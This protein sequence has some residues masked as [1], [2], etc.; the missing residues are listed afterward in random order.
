MSLATSPPPQCP[1]HAGEA[2]PAAPLFTP[3]MPKG[4][5]G[6][7][8]L[9][10]MLK[11]GLHSGIGMFLGTSYETQGVGR[12]PIPTLPRL[13]SR[14]LYMVRTP[15]LIRRVLVSEAD[16]FPKSAL[17][18]DML[19]A[20]TGYSIFIS[21]GEAWRRHRRLMDPAFETARIKDVF[22]MMVQAAD[23]CLARI[24]ARAGAPGAARPIRIDLEMTHYAADIIFRT[25]FSEPLPNADAKRFFAAFE[26]FQ[27][28]AYAH[29]MLRLAKVPTQWL[30]DHWR[31]MHAARVIRDILRRPLA[32][33]L[34][35][36]RAGEATPQADILATLLR[37]KDPEGGPGFDDAELL[38]QI[39]MLFLAGHET[40]ATAMA[41]S[42][43]LLA[44]APQVQ[45]RA[46]AEAVEVYDGRAPDWR[47][48]K[49][50]AFNRDV[51]REA[52]RLYPPVAFL[53]RDAGCP[54][55]LANRKVEQGDAIMVSPWIQQRHRAHW[56]APD[57]FDPDRFSRPES[58]EAVRQAYMPFSMGPRVCAGAAFALQ[59]ATLLL[60]LLLQR[61]RFLPEPGHTPDPVARL[62][63]RS[64]NGIPLRVE[65]RV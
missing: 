20:L 37:T 5:A 56:P 54:V 50:L 27:K 24:E 14:H 51:F 36:E 32:R 61:F 34:K 44:H 2:P 10:E 40:S 7:A 9:L 26:V 39:A 62:T 3:P 13:R 11:Y 65:M 33:R 30:P 47:D 58:T 16:A 64:A 23:A 29:G 63:L 31:A 18:D 15:D 60:S 41:W 38:D 46:H 52:M 8:S 19:R 6:K 45:D 22:P 4:P 28:I 57:A 21:N 35:A 43:Y 48:M 12:H 42:L 49:R 1:A 17:M 25:I 53:A 59:E 55:Q